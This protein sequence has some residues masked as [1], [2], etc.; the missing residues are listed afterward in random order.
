M[1]TDIRQKIVAGG[2]EAQIRAMSHEKGQGSL[3][4]SGVSKILEGLTT[5][6]EIIRVT[7]AE[8]QS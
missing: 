8:N 5:A 7:F 6:D 2:T 4:D 3:L 1:D